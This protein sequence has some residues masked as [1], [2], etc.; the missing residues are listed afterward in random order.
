VLD[1]VEA[2]VRTNRPAEAAAHGDVLGQAP[3]TALSPRLALVS[4]GAAAIAAPDRAGLEFFEAALAAP[5]AGRWP[6]DLARIQL[7]YGERLR[8]TR[9]IAPA[10]QHL[11]AAL[12]T[13]QRLAAPPW[14]DRARHELRATGAPLLE[15]KD[16]EPGPL[17]TQEREIA[18]LAAT[19]LTNK[20]IGEKLFLSHRTVGTHLYRVFPKLAITA[21][22]ALRDALALRDLT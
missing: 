20:Q 1:L 18:S 6:F 9:A 11:S 8:R 10:R 16:F 7:A 21:R 3:V 19:G 15:G 14:A 13:F 17:T 22:A 12:E 5:G 2:A 4:R